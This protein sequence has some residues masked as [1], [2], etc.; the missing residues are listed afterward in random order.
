MNKPGL[1]DGDDDDVLMSPDDSPNGSPKDKNQLKI[2]GGRYIPMAQG[3]EQ[4][5]RSH[6]NMKD[7]KEDSDMKFAPVV[8][9]DLDQDQK[10][11]FNNR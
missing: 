9:I 3:Y 5:A 1:V 10:L 8:Q 11:N 7:K 4:M 2:K 6:T